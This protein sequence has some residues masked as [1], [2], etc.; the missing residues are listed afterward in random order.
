M[1]LRVLLELTFQKL[2]VAD[3][4]LLYLLGMSIS[5]GK[6]VAESVTLAHMGNITTELC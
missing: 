3:T 2:V 1:Y 4:N 6:F 5:A